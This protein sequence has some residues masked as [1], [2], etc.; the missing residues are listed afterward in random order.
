MKA[1]QTKLPGVVTLEPATCGDE[2]GFFVETPLW[3]D[4][5]LESAWP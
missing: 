5:D 1:T 4:P 3:Y 2:G